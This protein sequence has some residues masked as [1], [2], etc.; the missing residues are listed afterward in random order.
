MAKT[1]NYYVPDAWHALLEEKGWSNTDVA[2]W[3]KLTPKHI[4]DILSGS[5]KKARRPTMKRLK[6]ALLLR[7]TQ[8]EF[9]KLFRSE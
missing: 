3:S 8:A 7:I 4:G 1:E 9:A 2:N 6:D 5:T